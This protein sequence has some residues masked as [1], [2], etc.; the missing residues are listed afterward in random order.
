MFKVLTEKYYIKKAVNTFGRMESEETI[1]EDVIEPS[2]R[3]PTMVES[4]HSDH[5]KQ[6]MGVVAS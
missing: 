4:N 5:I 1:Y 3:K 2:N 6:I